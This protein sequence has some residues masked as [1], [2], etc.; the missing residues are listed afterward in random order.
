MLRV[1]GAIALTLIMIAAGWVST[2]G[3]AE[4][5]RVVVL[6]FDGADARLVERWMDDGHLPNL[7]R[8]RAEGSFAPLRSTNPPQTPVSWSSFA[9][10]TDPGQTEI[11]DFIK[12]NPANYAPGFAMTTDSRR[13]Y[14]FGDRNGIWIGLGFAGLIFMLVLGLSPLLIRPWTVRLLAALLLGALVGAGAGIVAS[15]YLPTEVP[16]VI[17]NRKGRT[18]W[19]LVSQAGLDVRVVRV[20]A[21]FPAADIGDGRMISGLGVPDMRGRIGTPSFYTSEPGFE[22]GDDFSLELIKLAGRRGTLD[23]RIVGPPNKSFYDFVVSREVA[24]AAA[25]ERRNVRRDARRR[26]DE[27]G[28]PSRFDLPLALQANDTQL[29]IS[30]AGQTSTLSVGEWSDWFELPFSVNPLMD[31]V[32]PLVGIAR[33]KLLSLDPHLELYLSPINFHPDCHPVAFSWPPDYSD[34]IRSDYGLYKTIGWALDTWS[35][36]SGVGDDELFLEDMRF[37][38]D[39]YGEIM[40]GLLAE[41]DH[42]LYV[43]IFYFTDRVAHLFWRFIDPGHPLYDPLQAERYGNEILAAYQR[44]DELVGRARELVADD[45]VFIVCSDHGFSSFRRGVN[46]NNW[47]VENGWMTLKQT[48]T[49]TPALT[50]VDWSRTKAYALG[51]GSIYINLIGRERQGIVLPGPEYDEVMQ[52]IREGL[53]QLVDPKTGERPITRVAT[54]EELYGEYDPDLVPDLRVNNALNYRVSWGTTLGGF[55]D[56]IFEDNTNRWSG[57][58]ASNDPSVVPGIFLANRPIRGD[59][60]RMIDLMPTVLD[61]LGIEPPPEVEGRSVFR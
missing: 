32:D 30:V 39:R 20:P 6:G 46:Y 47:L 35:A 3:D 16:D 41:G 54:R 9:T 23:S 50:D 10:G 5:P 40:E 49:G 61:V 36:P 2:A 24:Q 26:L 34:E 1:R 14:L 11:F 13:T 33:F 31:T 58:H 60:P 21:T 22:A 57:D 8:L 12:R 42:D 4:S 7:A 38:V 59:S 43:Q 28:V 55:G 51:L 19:E 27:A 52:G 44:M 25:S 53:E 17:N 48:V 15:K 29:E 56:E 18:M 45:T 37:T